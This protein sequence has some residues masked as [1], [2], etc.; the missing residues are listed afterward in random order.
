MIA[1]TSYHRQQGLEARTLPG[2][3]NSNMAQ[4]TVHNAGMA[5]LRYVFGTDSNLSPLPCHISEVSSVRPRS[6]TRLQLY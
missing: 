6:S 4:D 2:L 3:A 5:S 1:K